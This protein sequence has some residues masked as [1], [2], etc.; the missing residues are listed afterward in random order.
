MVTIDMGCRVGG[1]N[2]DLTRT[3][4]VGKPSSEMKKIYGIV[5]DAQKRTLEKVGTGVPARSLDSVARTAIRNG[6]YGKF[7]RHSTGHGLGLELHELPRISSRSRNVLEQ[8]S[9]ITVEPGIYVPQLGGVRIED[10]IVVGE[11]DGKVLSG[12][13][14]ELLIV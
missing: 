2:C 14:K 3:V 11:K 6:G 1:Y 12:I 7:F 10:D 5:Y 9:V 4:S 8:G 13:Q